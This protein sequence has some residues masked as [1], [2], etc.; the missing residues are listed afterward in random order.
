M[1][2]ITSSVTAWM[3]AARSISRLPIALSGERGGP[4]KRAANFSPV[5]RELGPGR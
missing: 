3:E 2:S 5:M 1:S 4:P